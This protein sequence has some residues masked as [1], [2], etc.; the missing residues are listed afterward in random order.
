MY[1][2]LKAA[3]SVSMVRQLV[4]H[5]LQFGTDQGAAHSGGKYHSMYHRR[6]KHVNQWQ[7]LHRK[8]GELSTYSSHYLVLIISQLIS[9]KNKVTSHPW[10]SNA[11]ALFH[12]PTLSLGCKIRHVESKGSRVHNKKEE[13]EAANMCHYSLYFIYKPL[14]INPFLLLFCLPPLLPSRGSLNQSP[15][16]SIRTIITPHPLLLQRSLLIDS[17][18]HFPQ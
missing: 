2:G 18:A 16:L 8:R 1:I 7:S 17:V 6:G 13:R 12:Q 14:P 5:Q 10:F 11:M 4:S 15:G 3:F 9:F